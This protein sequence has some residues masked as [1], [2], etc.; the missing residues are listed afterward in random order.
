MVHSNFTYD[1]K[2]YDFAKVYQVYSEPSQTSKM[3]HLA[4]IANTWK[5]KA[6]IMQKALA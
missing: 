5:Q 3:K 2:T 6:L 4:K 1:S